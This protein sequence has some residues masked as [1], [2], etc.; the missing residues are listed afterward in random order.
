MGEEPPPV[1]KFNRSSG[2]GEKAGWEG[3]REAG[4]GGSVGLDKGSGGVKRKYPV[5]R[6]RR[7]VQDE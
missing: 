6:E 5:P 7:L 1:P 2:E 4:L 3:R